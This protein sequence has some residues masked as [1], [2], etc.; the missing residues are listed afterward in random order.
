[1]TPLLVLIAL[2]LVS[3]APA[4]PATTTTTAATST[5]NANATAASTANAT[6]TN[7]AATAT[8]DAAED[9]AAPAVV[10]KIAVPR[11]LDASIVKSA[12]GTPPRIVFLPG[13]CSN[14]NAYLQ[15]FPEAAK[16]H[17]GVVA[18]EGDQPCVPGFHSFSWDA[19]KQNARIEAALRASGSDGASDPPEGFTLVG[20]SQ[21]AAIGEQLVQRF[22]KR[23]ARV[24]LI[25]APTDPAASHF[26]TT[27]ALVTMSCSRD[28][29]SRMRDASRRAAAIGIPS[30]YI[31][32][33]GCTHGN[34]ADGERV[35]DSAFEFVYAN[36]RID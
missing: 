17:G 9:D 27:R 15:N 34:I 33:P 29:P 12:H 21:G 30:T 11:D 1:V 31:E 22:P 25:G 6:T 4:H 28:V 5:A 36:E 32:M 10:E 7:A 20:Y 19:T 23:Y 18:I 35:F 24:I 26:A 16:K 2:L 14:A 3:C 8:P 13:L